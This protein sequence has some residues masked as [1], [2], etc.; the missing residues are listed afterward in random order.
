MSHTISKS[1][2]NKLP[3]TNSIIWGIL[4]PMDTLVDVGK[5][6][7]VL[8]PHSTTSAYFCFLINTDGGQYD[9]T[10]SWSS[11]LN[12]YSRWCVCDKFYFCFTNLQYR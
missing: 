8:N 1:D 4:I 3:P 12:Y 7:V 11:V 10:Q 6:K 9:H 2:F 5:E